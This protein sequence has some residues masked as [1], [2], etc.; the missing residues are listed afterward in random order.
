[1]DGHDQNPG[2]APRGT[3]SLKPDARS[4][5]L[6]PTVAQQAPGRSARG[7]RMKSFTGKVA[8]ITGAAS[9]IG[10]ELA[11]QLIAEGARVALCDL[12]SVELER[13][14]SLCMALAASSPETAD[15]NGPRVT[16]DVVD[17][18]DRLAVRQFARK[19]ATEHGGVDLVFN[20]AGVALGSMVQGLAYED[21]EWIMNINFWG[22][23]YGT[24]EFLPYLSQSQ[25]GYVINMSSA[26]GLVAMP[27]QSGYNA[28][29]FAVRGFTDALRMELDLVGSSVC[30]TCVYPGG[31]K[32]NIARSARI[33]DNMVGLLIEDQEQAKRQFEK[34][35]NISAQRAATII[36]RGVKRRQRRILIGADAQFFDLL[37]RLFP[38]L[39]QPVVNWI[40]S[41]QQR[42][43]LAPRS[44]A[45][46]SPR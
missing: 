8:A 17:V 24:R 37:A 42:R 5:T 6:G 22:V 21:L 32:T 34:R 44:A 7:V 38:A 25:A 36:L 2:V 35:L 3:F 16:H 33:R 46:A 28:S 31:I 43:G 15:S 13:T 10:R 19:V 26:F 27:G 4:M 40:L 29:K 1:M 12:D 9:G 23:V 41:R 30:A 45:D 18:A 39:Y 20:N 11:L 14:A